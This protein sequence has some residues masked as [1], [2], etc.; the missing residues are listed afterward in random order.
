MSTNRI[1]T[2]TSSSVSEDPFRPL[3]PELWLRIST[4]SL[5][6][7]YVLSMLSRSF[8]GLL[9]D[10]QLWKKNV[11]RQLTAYPTLRESNR[12]YKNYFR[13]FFNELE[14]GKIATLIRDYNAVQNE[15]NLS[16]QQM[17]G[18]YV[19]THYQPTLSSLLDKDEF[20]LELK[21]PIFNL[22]KRCMNEN[23][24]QLLK[25]I[26]KQLPKTFFNKALYIEL[27][28]QKGLYQR[29]NPEMLPLLLNL[30]ADEP[31]TIQEE[32]I[33]AGCYSSLLDEGISAPV[34]PTN[35]LQLWKKISLE[36]R[37]LLL[38]QTEDI[39]YIVLLVSFLIT[40]SE[41]SFVYPLLPADQYQTIIKQCLYLFCFSGIDDIEQWKITRDANAF[42]Q[43]TKALPFADQSKILSELLAL[44]QFFYFNP[45]TIVS[46]TS[47]PLTLLTLLKIDANATI[48]N[49]FTGGYGGYKYKNVC[50]ARALYCYSLLA[51]DSQLEQAIDKTCHKMLEADFVFII[52]YVLMLENAH[53]PRNETVMVLENIAQQ[54]GPTIEPTAPFKRA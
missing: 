48:E 38:K 34:K 49:A 37:K 51:S 14:M 24:E 11:K 30:I 5:G 27:F 7:Q 41:V 47:F 40:Y 16:L 44:T 8:A 2:E 29:N 39:S 52:D 53:E 13:H 1:N 9:A 10:N 12:P 17:V 28:K 43:L 21:K 15:E 42:K 6:T 22:L 23:L 19:S 35:F 32:I 3:F 4:Q 50:I 18:H 25:N 45:H 36:T 26:L 31:I 54:I 46:N 33:A 20:L